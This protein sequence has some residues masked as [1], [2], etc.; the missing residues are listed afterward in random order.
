MQRFIRWGLNNT[1]AVIILSI[2]VLVAGIFSMQQIRVESF[3]NI[4][5]PAL[6]ITITKFGYPAEDIEQKVVKPIEDRLSQM[7]DIDNYISS[8]NENAGTVFIVYPFE[9][10]IDQAKTKIQEEL[11][12][13]SLPEGAELKLD[14]ISITNMP[15]YQA[16][17]SSSDSS[18]LQKVIEN[19]MLPE[20]QKVNGVE[21]AT[22]SG[23][24]EQSWVVEVDPDKA[25]KV[26]I[27]IQSIHDAIQA[28]NYSLPVGKVKE[29]AYSIPVRLSGGIA[30]LDD[31]KKLNISSGQVSMAPGQGLPDS[32]GVGQP[33][34]ASIVKL[35]DIA[36]IKSELKQ[37]EITRFNGKGSLIL[38]VTKADT[39]NS[40]EVSVAVKK[41]VNKY[42]KQE[43]FT[44]FNILD[45]GQEVTKSIN[46]LVK[47][48]L[49]GALFTILVIAIFL[50]NIR[51]TLIAILS[52]PLSI[53]A[54]I[55]LLDQLGYTLNMMTLGGLAVAVGRIV[56][57]SIVVIENIFRWK[58]QNG[59]KYSAKQLAF[60]ATK[61]VLK[62]VTSS[63]LV[64]VVVFLPLAF[65]T[66]IIG[67]FFRP[68]ALAVVFSI[69]FSFLVAF[70]LIPVLSSKFFQN[71]KHREKECRLAN[72]F[73]KVLRSALRRKAIPV[74]FSIILLAGSLA[75][76]PRL[77]FSFLPAGVASSVDI[78]IS[79]P[80][81]TKKDQTNKMAQ[82]V[83]DYI[84]GLKEVN[85]SQ[86]S[87]GMVQEFTG[88][89]AKENEAT[90]IL[91]LKDG[92][93]VDPVIQKVEK[94]VTGFVHADF[95]SGVVEVKE[96]QQ[97]GPPTGNNVDFKLF[98]EDLRAL[99][100]G[101]QQVE[102]LLKEN[103]QLK[104]VTNNMNE[105][106]P[107][108][109]M[110]LNDKGKELQIDINQIRGVVGDYLQGQSID[111]F[112]IGKA[113][114]TLNIA[115][116]KGITSLTELE[117]IEIL[118]SSG[119]K[120]LGD[121]VTITEAKMPVTIQHDKGRNYAEITAI[122][123]TTDTQ[124]VT[125]DVTNQVKSLKLPKGVTYETA[126]GFQDTTEGFQSMGIAMGVAIGLV[127][128]IL[129][130]TFGGVATPLI[131][132]SSLLFV[133]IGSIT[134]LMLTGQ[135][136]SMSAMIGFLMLIGIVVTNAVVLLDRIETNRQSGMELVEAIV[137]GAKT[138]LRPILM[139]AFATIFALLPLA[140]SASSS[141]LISKGL[142]VTV[143]GGLT[144]STLLTL[145]FVPVL[146]AIFRKRNKE[147]EVV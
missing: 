111:K 82:R 116:S 96:G 1:V 89:A 27:T 127:F 32:I 132:L 5:F 55:S 15:V 102:T 145:I 131:I 101:S 56:D 144:T 83:E 78:K 57:D 25:K 42:Q 51:A 52:L 117:N 122:I 61:E 74:T 100:K 107:K 60:Y 112:E 37:N 6:G 115:Y 142:A 103:S 130:V 11:N 143:I 16:A 136:L 30:K 124:K 66:G 13:L 41:I 65:V 146:Y 126:G 68:F 109:N 128:L 135:T 18:H 29:P 113:K 134:G 81:T 104:N 138:R 114:Q 59:K 10:D 38:N 84:K 62:A 91:K 53:F 79:L 119:N 63:T 87:L 75:M 93:A 123:K 34:T 21:T 92:V 76:I 8:S 36:T 125:Q 4:N 108:W 120:K 58:Q 110:V 2:L 140:L 35:S 50:R 46:S 3:P 45:D 95:A 64:T 31:L 54:S 44:N 49:L 99:E 77:G 85:Y 39:A 137:E 20:L 141:E 147:R 86:M 19:E 40:P 129:S 73:E 9:Q 33:Q 94:K 118:T 88:I 14:K 106:L 69:A 98:S 24:K 133:P 22:L 72:W 67:Q 7:K 47:E 71:V 121:I 70:L 17:L 28:A 23:G 97:N 12:K 139:T 48:G 105:V 43:K 80:A 26:G 90:F